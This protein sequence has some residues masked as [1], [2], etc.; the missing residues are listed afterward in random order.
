[1]KTFQ[2]RYRFEAMDTEDRID[3]AAKLF[4]EAIINHARVA[5]A[6]SENPRD[7]R[8]RRRSLSSPLLVQR[9]GP[10]VSIDGCPGA[11]YADA[12]RVVPQ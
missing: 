12:E 1:V 5:K 7:R 4:F 6:R 2:K 11:S 8:R 3:R 10:S 9:R